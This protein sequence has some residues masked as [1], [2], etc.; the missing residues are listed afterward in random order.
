[1]FSPA[2]QAEII[3]AAKRE[4]RKTRVQPSQADRSKPNAKRKPGERFKVGAVNR[5]I[6]KACK[7]A[8]IPHWHVHQLRQSASLAFSREMG[9]EAARAALGHATVDMSAMYAGRDLEAAKSVAAK[10]G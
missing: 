5:A 3:K 4:A 8:G 9:L 2:K 7:K 10:I 6:G 1:M